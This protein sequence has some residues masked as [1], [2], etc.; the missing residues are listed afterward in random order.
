M[1]C[2]LLIAMQFHLPPFVCILVLL[3]PCL[4]AAEDAFVEGE[5]LVVF[6]PGFAKAAAK[7]ALTRHA[8]KWDRRY[9]RISKHSGRAIGLV[10]NKGLGTAKLIERLMADPNVEI[11]EPNYLRHFC[12]VTPNDTEFPKLW[13]L[14]NTG[15]TVNGVTGTSGADPNFVPAWRLARTS[16]GE[17]VVGVVDSGVDITHPD[18]A[19]NIWTNPGE[20][21][22]NGIDDDGNGYV[23]DIRGYDFGTNTATITDYDHHGTHVAGTIAAVGKTALA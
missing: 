10:K 7:T 11:A 2:A 8:L 5:V 1:S 15:Q 23:D 6:K 20:I 16:S 13:G 18:L 22:G 3:C 4:V 9:G 21:A 17:V 14:Q 19:A 12:S